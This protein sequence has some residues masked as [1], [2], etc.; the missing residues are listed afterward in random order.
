MRGEMDPAQAT[1]KL[2][3]VLALDVCGY[4][5]LMEMDEEGTLGRLKAH[6]QEVLDPA[7]ARH[8]GRIVKTT[9]DGLL[10][11][12]A[13]PVEA[14]RCALGIQ[15]SMRD[16]NAGFSASQ[17]MDMR[18]G[19]NVGDVIA[20]G[21][22]LFGDGVN[23]AARL[24]GLAPPGGICI[25]DRVRDDVRGKIELSLE[26]MGPQRLKNIE[27]QVHVHSVLLDGVPARA[28][29]LLGIDMSLPE[30]PSIA[31][32]PFLDMS[33]DATQE[34]FTDGITED[35]IT[36]LS[37]FRSLFVIAK[38]STF[39][40]KGRTADPRRVS[41]ELGVRY[42]VEGSIR[43]AANRV[44]VTAQLVDAVSG[45]HLWG[46]RYDRV[47]E[48]IFAVQEELTRSIIAQV[49]PQIDQAEQAKAVR[50][51]PDN[52]TA[53]EIAVRSW[54]MWQQAWFKHDTAMRNESMRL[55]REALAIDPRSVR[56]LDSLAMCLWQHIFY[57]TAP[58]IDA[59]RAEGL[60]AVARAIDLDR[61]DHWAHM[62]KGL[63][64]ALSGGAPRWDEALHSARLDR[65]HRGRGRVSHR[66]HEAGAEGEP[67]R[68]LAQQRAHRARARKLRHSGLRGG[69]PLGA[70]RLLAARVASQH[71]GLPRGAGRPRERAR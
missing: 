41:A 67:A 29:R 59:A 63:L 17:R 40:Y 1:R 37:R 9:G 44:R 71:R 7:I 8:R 69:H 28:A 51:R 30:K 50:K 16:R 49:A 31:V 5:R 36:E 26:D 68:P 22:D 57:R 32:M 55:A 39:T 18:I 54:T 21:D 66:A 19:V 14:V 33:P 6:R 20:D 27:R 10:A 15:Q 42:I 25:S 13:S 11:E 35:V 48:D 70:A 3:A 4:S 47:I 34:A 52:L 43:R 62:L 46:E 56:A 64:L 45:K 65:D 2:A 61:T 24:E 58:D 53:Y 23:I 12:F 60:D 38:N